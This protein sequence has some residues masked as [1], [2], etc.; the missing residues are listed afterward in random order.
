MPT[1]TLVPTATPLP[2]ATPFGLIGL[3]NGISLQAAVADAGTVGEAILGGTSEAPASVNFVAPPGIGVSAVVEARDPATITEAVPALKAASESGAVQVRRSI[4]VNLYDNTSGRK[5]VEHDEPVVIRMNFD[6][7]DF[8]AAGS[9]PDRLGIVVVRATAD[10]TPICPAGAFL[11]PA[12]Y[13]GDARTLT[14]GTR[15]TSAFSVV[16]L[17]DGASDVDYEI[18]G[19]R[20]FTQ[21]SGFGGRGGVGYAVIDDGQ[22]SFAAEFSRRG[23]LKGLGYPSS[24]RFTRDGFPVQVF[25]KFILQWR[26][27]RNEAVVVNVF[28]ELHARGYDT[29]LNDVHGV[30]PPFDMQVDEDLS[31]QEVLRLHVGNILNGRDLAGTAVPGIDPQAM[32][33]IQKYIFK[34]DDWLNQY[35]L[36]V[37]VARFPSSIVVRMQRAAFQ[38][39]LEDL[40][41]ASAGQITVV[42][43]GDLAKQ[44]GLYRNE[45]VSPELPQAYQRVKPVAA[46]PSPEN[47]PTPTPGVKAGAMPTPAGAVVKPAVEED[48]SGPTSFLAPIWNTVVDAVRTMLPDWLLGPLR[49]SSGSARGA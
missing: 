49:A 12:K 21:A 16:V 32:L 7:S 20:F 5:L 39:W 47:S 9:D 23:G 13:D 38:Y 18:Q 29:Y 40:P 36:P 33:S 41:W 26:A 31:Y 8:E 45:D 1:A 6:A 46:T 11:M 17:S 42:L 30:P 2:T 28:D 43:G 27:D 14:I 34:D 48:A 22:A 44:A 3:A 15:C 4:Q 10:A 25:Q 24:R 19:G 35:G 37:S